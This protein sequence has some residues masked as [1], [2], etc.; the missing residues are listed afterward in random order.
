V[1]L[2]VN[3]QQY[4]YAISIFNEENTILIQVI[5]RGKIQL[6]FLLQIYLCVQINIRRF[7]T[8]L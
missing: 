6:K 7:S 3:K 4:F 5:L 1:A 2:A 8:S